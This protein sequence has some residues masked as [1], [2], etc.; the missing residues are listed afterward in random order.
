MPDATGAPL[1]PASAVTG[2]DVPATL[3]AEGSSPPSQK[4][5]AE[6]G[7]QAR[8][9]SLLS[10][11]RF[12]S[13][14]LCWALRRFQIPLSWAVEVSLS[15]CI[16]SLWWNGQAGKWKGSSFAPH[17]G[18]LTSNLIQLW[19]E[20]LPAGMWS[21]SLWVPAVPFHTKQK[22]PGTSDFPFYVQNPVSLLM[23]NFQ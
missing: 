17:T 19:E 13:A 6:H 4:N 16:H 10:C 18:N 15:I 1:D 12:P 5:A 3:L 14:Q 20:W 23:R 11:F 8:I 22:F 7:F 2:E 21:S 9:Y